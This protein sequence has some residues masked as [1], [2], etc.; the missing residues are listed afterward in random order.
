MISHKYSCKTCN[1]HF[2]H[3][4]HYDK[5]KMLLHPYENNTD[6]DIIY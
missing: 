1:K 2:Y 3:K 5:H 4:I 6:V